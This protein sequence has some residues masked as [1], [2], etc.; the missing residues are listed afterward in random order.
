MS[1]KSLT[2]E[3]ARDLMDKGAVLIDIRASNEYV[4]EHIQQSRHLPMEQLAAQHVDLADT[5]AV[6]F[7]CRSGNRTQMQAQTLS[8]CTSCD[9]Y[10]LEGGLDAW[11]KAGLPIVADHSQPLELQRQVQITAGAIIVLGAILGA[12]VSPKFHVLSGFVGVGLMFAGI[13]GY[14][15]MARLLMKMPW[16]QRAVQA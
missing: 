11:K 14:C 8:N 12:T 13:T 2:P 15:G 3:A 9:T 1:L 7:Y 10:I 5:N 6:I 4:R 16:N